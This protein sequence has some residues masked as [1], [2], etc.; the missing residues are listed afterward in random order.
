MP[1]QIP[2]ITGQEAVK[3]FCKHGYVHDRTRGSHY[4]LKHPNRRE[5]LSI[6]VHGSQIVGIGLLRSQIKAA[7]LTP[8][9]FSALM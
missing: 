5:R 1:S 4:I 7:G 9:D 6:P 2:R 3:A 8:E